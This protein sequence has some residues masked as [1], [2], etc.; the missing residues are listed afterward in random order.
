MGRYSCRLE[1]LQDVCQMIP[2]E[3]IDSFCH[4]FRVS[5][6]PGSLSCTSSTPSAATTQRAAS[7][8]STP[9]SMKFESVPSQSQIPPPK[10]TKAREKEDKV[11]AVRGKVTNLEGHISHLKAEII[12]LKV[13]EAFL[14]RLEDDLLVDHM[15]D[16]GVIL[17][18]GCFEGA[19]G[20]YRG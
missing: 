19:G 14:M 12:E 3:A 5:D 7:Y 6:P 8:R 18:E 11:K 13:E 1:Q 4:I 15:I 10:K 16:R 17:S 9:F 20:T 2:M